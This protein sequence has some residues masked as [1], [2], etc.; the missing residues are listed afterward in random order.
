M[1]SCDKLGKIGV[2]K[3]PFLVS[4]IAKGIGSSHLMLTSFAASILNQSEND[5]RIPARFGLNSP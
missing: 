3:R 2:S 5:L 1:S 4:R